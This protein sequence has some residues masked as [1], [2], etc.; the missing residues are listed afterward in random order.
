M[1]ECMCKPSYKHKVENNLILAALYTQFAFILLGMHYNTRFSGKQSWIKC[2][3]KLTAEWEIQTPAPK[4]TR[5]SGLEDQ[6][7][8]L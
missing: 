4:D 8:F 7:V 6:K 5:T 1:N 3:L 2:D